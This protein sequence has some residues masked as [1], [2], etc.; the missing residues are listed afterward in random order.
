MGINY[1]QPVSISQG[2]AIV[3][4]PS[5]ISEMSPTVGVG[6]GT[7]W[8]EK[9]AQPAEADTESRFLGL[10]ERGPGSKGPL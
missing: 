1:R 5:C 2:E 7:A 4:S 9:S 8:N 3:S 10:D 6:E